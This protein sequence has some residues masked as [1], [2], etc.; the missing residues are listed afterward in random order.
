M[1]F[2]LAGVVA[3]ITLVF[4]FMI[5]F[6]NGMSDNPSGTGI[7][8]WPTLLIG[9]PIAGLLVASHWWFQTHWW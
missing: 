3:A 6:A 7:P 5:W 2:A 8:I 9:L 4:A 1:S